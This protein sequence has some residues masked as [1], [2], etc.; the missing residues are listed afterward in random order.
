MK[1]RISLLP[2]GS[3]LAGRVGPRGV[4]HPALEAIWSVVAAIPPGRVSSYGAVAEAAGLPGRARQAG[5]ALRHAP[6]GLDLP[7]HR[8]LAAGGRIAFPPGSRAA[9]QQQRLLEAE[10]VIVRNGRA[11]G[12]ALLSAEGLSLIRLR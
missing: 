9:R 4:D 3:R 2:A 5:F 10:G 1:P 11:A 6:A 8:V 12:E 7:W